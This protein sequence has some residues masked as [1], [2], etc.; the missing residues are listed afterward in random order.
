[1]E[2]RLGIKWATRALRSIDE[3]SKTISK[4]DPAAAEEVV[5]LIRSRGE[6]LRLFPRMYEEALPG[7]RELVISRSYLISYRIR[8]GRNGKQG[9]VEIIQVWHTARDR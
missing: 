2:H 1:M 3:I 5:R 4:H 6:R 8:Q 9:R 7:I